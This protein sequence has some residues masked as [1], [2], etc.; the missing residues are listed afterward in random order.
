M[1]QSLSP[2]APAAIRTP[3]QRGTEPGLEE[4]QRT[5][6]CALFQGGP[7]PGER[8]TGR[9]RALVML[10]CLSPYFAKVQH[11]LAAFCQ[12]HR[13]CARWAR[14]WLLVGLSPWHDAGW[15]A[16]RRIASG[17][18]ASLLASVGYAPLRWHRITVDTRA[19]TPCLKAW[20]SHGLSGSCCTNA[21]S[22]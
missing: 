6:R 9:Y 20:R 15:C 11:W 16:R 18:A 5:R 3:C 13:S 7:A 4:S 8:E 10:A 14:A 1:A 17:S 21:F 2:S 22:G 12:S 19:G